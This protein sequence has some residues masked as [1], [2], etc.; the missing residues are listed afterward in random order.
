VYIDIQAQKA[1]AVM[2][3]SCMF[4]ANVVTFLNN[5]A[6]NMGF[7]IIETPV[8][9]DGAFIDV[10]IDVSL[11]H[12]FPGLF[13]YNGYDVRGV[14]IGEASGTLAY[15]ADLT[16]AQ[17]GVTDQVMYDYNLTTVDTH[18]GLVGM[19]DG[20]TRWW[21][22]T[23]FKTT[24]D[25][26]G[27]TQGKL[28]TPAYTPTGTLNP[29]KYF[30]DGL[31]ADDDLWT[32]LSVPANTDLNGVFSA[33]TTNTRNYYLRFPT[34]TPNV[35]Y[36]YAVC[37]NWEGEGPEFHPSNAPEAIAV[38]TTITPDLYFV[39][40]T[41]KGG[42][43]IADI[44]VFNWSTVMQESCQVWVESTVLSAPHQFDPTEMTPIGGGEFYSTY[45]TEILADNVTGLEGNQMWVIVEQPGLDYTNV[46][47]V[48]NL[49]DIDTL[50]AFFRY[51]LFVSPYPYCSTGFVSITPNNAVKGSTVDNA[52]IVCT[53]LEAGPNLGAKLTKTGQSDIVGTDIQ[54]IDATTM[55]ADFSLVGA[56][57]GFWNV[58]VTNGCGGTK[59][60]GANAFEVIPCENL[61]PTVSK[62]NGMA[63]YATM[64]GPFTGWTVLG[65]KFEAG[66]GLGVAA[67]Q[68]GIDKAVGTNV[69]WVDVNTI[70]F[71]IDLTG[72][73]V[74]TYDITVTNGCGT[75]QKGTGT[76]LLVLLQKINVIGP[77]NIN[78]GSGMKDIGIN[79]S[80]DQVMINRGNSWTAYTANYTVA[81]NFSWWSGQTASFCDG[82]TW[83]ILYGCTFQGSSGYPVFT[84]QNWAGVQSGNAWWFGYASAPGIKDV[85]NCQGTTRDI[86]AYDRD[87]W[88]ALIFFDSSAYDDQGNYLRLYNGAPFYNGSGNNGV[89]PN[90]LR[91]IDFKI[92][93]T[94]GPPYECYLLE[95]D[96]SV[97][98][99][100][101]ERWKLDLGSYDGSGITTFELAF[102][103]NFLYNPLDITVDSSDNIWVLEI[104]ANGKP[105][106]WAYNVSGTVF[107]TTG[108][109]STADVSGT[110]LRIDCMLSTTP[111]QV[112]MVHSS[113]VTRFSL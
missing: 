72:Q 34:P 64:P 109:L 84:W 88:P 94:S 35:K 92:N 81:S 96:P 56:V 10:D 57:A 74:G 48:T 100:T 98:T 76:G 13:M 95:K 53:E 31:T 50:A 47:G 63:Q 91:A 39:D 55:T 45:R 43:I 90:N 97:N 37:A 111:D 42:S 1:E 16:Y 51:D 69:T 52:T 102:G 19:P 78:V 21:N 40:D 73:P 11:T 67:T 26:L 32:W 87:N 15:N 5:P 79:P 20:Y 44:S 77:P 75:M 110:P 104:N 103:E 2:N 23:E 85:A 14:F 9:P 62:L 46:Y 86:G 33:G 107:A 66:T 25:V 61:V 82:Q 36:E 71:D 93:A 60:V 12:P 99:G 30:A 24:M 38:I 58:V 3:R 112:H 54:L 83:G 22:P 68:G 18:T 101:I 106:I 28:G 80:Q 4:T 59:G 49:A 41:N 113:G 8:D 70:T 17:Y 105:V 89:I 65:D 29:Y 108:E 27:Y 7:V 6:T